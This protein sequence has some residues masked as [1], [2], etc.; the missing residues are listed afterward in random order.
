VSHFVSHFASRSHHA[1]FYFVLFA[2]MGIVSPY[3]GLWLHHVLPNTFS[4]V[5]SGFYL[6]LI[7]VPAV[8]GHFAFASD[9][10]GLWLRRG[11]LIASFTALGLTFISSSNTLGANIIILMTFGVFFNPLTA[12]LDAM[13]SA[14][15]ADPGDYAR[16][17]LY[18]SVGFMACSFLV[19][20]TVVLAHPDSFP[21]L[22][23]L[24]L[25]FV[26]WRARSYSP[27][28]FSLP[29]IDTP[30]VFAS[31]KTSMARLFPVWWVAFFTQASFACYYTFFAMA[32]LDRGV[33]NLMIGFAF[34]VATASEVL[35]FRF[36]D[37]LF[38]KVSP[39]TWVVAAS[40]CTAVRWLSLSGIIGFFLPLVLV[41]QCT[42]ALG[43]S[44]VHTAC[45]TLIRERVPEN[46]LGTMQG[47]YNAFG[48]GVGGVV[49]VF[50]GALVWEH[51]EHS[52]GLFELALVLAL[53]AAAGA[54]IVRIR[55]SRVSLI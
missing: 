19:G 36:M 55:E 38:K 1:S 17:R 11:S 13:V 5:L 18:G 8:W 34:A 45:M 9:R 29:L 26:W 4:F 28:D 42:Q 51:G 40:L 32:L 6:T 3:L 46:H 25:F 22:V 31:I 43:F 15:L 12:L 39:W 44:L 33:S 7:L 20:G 23:A 41:L 27:V 53:F 48:F 54:L 35:A 30:S 49:G 37:K 2:A 24:S 14:E 16:V 10:P 52:R 21:F 50:L 47:L